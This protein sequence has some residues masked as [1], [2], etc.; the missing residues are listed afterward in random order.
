MISFC[1]V[2]SLLKHDE[3]QSIIITVLV[4]IFMVNINNTNNPSRLRG[5]RG[6]L[7]HLLAPSSRP[8]RSLARDGLRLLRRSPGR[9]PEK[10]AGRGA[11]SQHGAV[12]VI[13]ALITK[14]IKIITISLIPNI[15]MV[16]II[17]IP[18]ITLT[19]V[20]IMIQLRM[21]LII[22]VMRI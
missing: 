17:R 21:R 5:P 18:M 2:R 11:S 10:H 8:P 4:M 1:L 19:I 14:I 7:V 13:I 9:Q 6:S 16:I 15:R 3:K 22:I 20:I 12:I